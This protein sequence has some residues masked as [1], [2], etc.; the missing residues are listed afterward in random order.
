MVLR[1]TLFTI[2]LPAFFPGVQSTHP[3][4]TRSLI[5]QS[6]G[7]RSSQRHLKNS[8]LKFALFQPLTTEKATN[9]P[10]VTAEEMVTACR[11]PPRKQTRWRTNFREPQKITK[12]AARPQSPAGIG[13]RPTAPVIRAAGPSHAIELP[14]RVLA[15]YSAGLPNAGIIAWNSDTSEFTPETIGLVRIHDRSVISGN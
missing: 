14:T 3:P 13:C 9:P 11:F 2:D 12:T 7:S 1:P 6:I 8:L 5:R 15:T 4:N 10:A